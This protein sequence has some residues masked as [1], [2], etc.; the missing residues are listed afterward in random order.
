MFV[1][2]I[3]TEHLPN[4]NLQYYPYNILLDIMKVKGKAIP[5]TGLEGL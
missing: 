5:V 2:E 4:K 3:R 1:T